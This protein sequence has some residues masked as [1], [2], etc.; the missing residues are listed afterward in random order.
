MT[1]IMIPNLPQRIVGKE[2]A[3]ILCY[4]VRLNQVANLVDAYILDVLPIV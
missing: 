3:K 1:K 2:S 4:R